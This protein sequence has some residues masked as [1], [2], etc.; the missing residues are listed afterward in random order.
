[1]SSKDFRQLLDKVRAQGF[2]VRRGGS[3][4]YVVTSP[5]G[6]VVSVSATP[7]GGRGRSLTNAKA[8]LRRIGA[9]L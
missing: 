6:Q 2:D 1:V 3:G 8:T 5:D 7:T 9:A 4:H